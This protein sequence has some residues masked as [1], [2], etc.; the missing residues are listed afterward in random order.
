MT[1][2]IDWGLEYIW[3]KY[4][5]YRDK[6]PFIAPIPQLPPV[7]DW[8]VVGIPA[9]IYAAGKF[10][11]SEMM[12]DI[13]EGGLLYSVAMFLKNILYRNVTA[14]PT[15]AMIRRVS[16]SSARTTGQML[17]TSSLVQVD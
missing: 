8:I 4:P 5:E 9:G 13:G 6:F 12:K 1:G 14:T 11:G 17:P 3:E 7:D 2:I 15:S 10:T 16:V